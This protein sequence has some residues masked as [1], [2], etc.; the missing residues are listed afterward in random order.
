[1]P[2]T[3]YA[4]STYDLISMTI[5]LSH[6]P[7]DNLFTA[8]AYTSD[9]HQPSRLFRHGSVLPS[10]IILFAPIFDVL[11]HAPHGRGDTSYDFFN[12]KSRFDS[13]LHHC[14]SNI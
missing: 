8:F 11:L 1:M 5:R 13:F 14:I 10:S 4:P 7:V 3:L 2:D 12:I 9:V 6:D